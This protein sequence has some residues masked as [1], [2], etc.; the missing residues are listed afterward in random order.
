MARI[1][2]CIALKASPPWSLRAGTDTSKRKCN[3]ISFRLALERDLGAPR[4]GADIKRLF[5]VSYSEIL[6]FN[7]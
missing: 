3:K 7:I 5:Q 2:L 1:G 4:A 6:N